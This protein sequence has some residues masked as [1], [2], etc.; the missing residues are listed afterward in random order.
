LL[1]QLDNAQAGFRSL[2]GTVPDPSESKVSLLV[3]DGLLRSGIDAVNGNLAAA[4]RA[5]ADGILKRMVDANVSAMTSNVDSYL[6]QLKQNAVGSEPKPIDLAALD[7]A[8][9]SAVDSTIK[10]WTVAQH[11]LERLLQRRIDGLLGKLRNSLLLIGTLS[12][13]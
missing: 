13:F 1:G 11:E 10:A 3:L 2:A 9:A 6:E 5:N 7:G 8:Y 4:Y 12:A